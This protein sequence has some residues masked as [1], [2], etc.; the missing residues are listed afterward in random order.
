M[1]VHGVFWWYSPLNRL[2][3][4]PPILLIFIKQTIKKKTTNP[5]T[6]KAT[7]YLEEWKTYPASGIKKSGREALIKGWCKIFHLR[8]FSGRWPIIPI[9]F[10]S[11]KKA[12][13]VPPVFFPIL[14]D[15]VRSGCSWLVCCC[16]GV[17][18]G[19]VYLLRPQESTEPSWE[20]IQ[21]S[22]GIWTSGKTWW[23]F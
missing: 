22:P 7:M 9:E 18:R 16:V 4:P 15:Y 10:L 3:C 17:V 8:D 23:T 5:T 20:V 21:F 19:S 14:R 1:Y 6:C 12:F 13:N 2:S 11:L